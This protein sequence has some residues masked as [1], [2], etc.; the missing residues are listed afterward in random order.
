MMTGRGKMS[1][2]EE[3]KEETERAIYYRFCRAE[4]CFEAYQHLAKF[5]LYNKKISSILI[6]AI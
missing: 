3:V 5:P 4:I 1:K 2:R 6:F